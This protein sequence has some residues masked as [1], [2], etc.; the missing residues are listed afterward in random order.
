MTNLY[1]VR[2][3]DPLL[4]ADALRELVDEVL[5]GQDRSLAVEEFAIPG[6]ADGDEEVGGAAGRAAVL[7]SAIDA[8]Q[9][10]PFMTDRR[11]VII[12]EIGACS[13]SDVVPLVAYLDDPMPT[14]VMILVAG[15]GRLAPGITKA[16]KAS[17][18]ER[19]PVTEDVASVLSERA[20]A[21]GIRLAPDALR[22]VTEHLGS[23][24]GR[25]PQ[26]VELLAST[27]GEGARLSEADVLPYLGE[28]GSIPVYELANAV[29]A[30]DVAG[31]LTVL[32]RMLTVTSMQQPK[33]MHPLQVLAMLHN[34]VRRLALL[35]DPSIRTDAQAVEALG[36]KVKPY[37]AKKALATS[38]KWGSERIRQAYDALADADLALKGASAMPERTVVE[39]LVARLAGL[40]Q[41]AGARR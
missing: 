7:A 4:R 3:D 15:G 39:I 17:G 18:E 5:A 22:A 35:D 27:Y 9:S 1:L 13:A 30:G 14:T 37:P 23:D 26:I 36:G 28:A 34:Q 20:S 16:C 29:E 32:D 11:V 38:R 25:V 12:R 24:A 19:G 40:S 21:A 10:P 33:P 31:A 8:A 6:R 2:G 41:R